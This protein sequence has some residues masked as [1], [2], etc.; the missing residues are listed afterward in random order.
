VT[1]GSDIIKRPAE[2]AADR[3]TLFDLQFDLND[4]PLIN[5][6]ALDLIARG[7]LQVNGSLEEPRVRGNIVIN[8]GRINLDEL[9]DLIDETGE[10]PLLV[11]ARRKVFAAGEQQADELVEDS[12]GF[13]IERLRGEIT[14]S[15]PRNVWVRSSDMNLEISADLTIIV[16]GDEFEVFG[17]L[18]TIR[19]YYAFYGKRF[20]IVTGDVIFAGGKEFNP[21]LT[22]EAIYSF[23]GQDMVRKNLKLLVSGTLEEM[24]LEFELNDQPIEEADAISYIILGR[25]FDEL[26]QGEKNEVSD[27]ALA[28]GGFLA[29]RLT[30]QIATVIGDSFSLDVIEFRSDTATS[31]VGIEIGKYLTDKLF[32]SYKRDF[33]FSDTKE[34]V[35]EEILVEYEITR[36]LYLQLVR[37][38]AK[39][40]GMDLIWRYKWR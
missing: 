15:F 9:L 1:L 29:N 12:N 16:E 20:Q 37:V 38:D 24:E 19:G 27:Q 23:R 39:D 5:T 14:V 18:S 6:R 4:F 36:F 31:Q 22:L 21:Q 33:S 7:R 3:P 28:I 11:E 8:R 2:E 13:S 26:T 25:S 32:I 10:E 17:N 40:T 34:P 30:D 35:S